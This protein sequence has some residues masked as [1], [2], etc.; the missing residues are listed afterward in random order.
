MRSSNKNRLKDKKFCINIFLVL[1][2]LLTIFFQSNINSISNNNKR[3][4]KSPELAASVS[5]L[6]NYT[7]RSYMRSSPALGDVDSDGIL[8]VIIGSGN[9]KVYALNGKDGSKLW[10]LYTGDVVDSS[11]ALGDVDGD[12][13]LE[14]VIGNWDNKVYALNGEDGSEFWNFT[15]GGD[16]DS[17]PAL[18]DV[19]GDGMLEVVVSS[20]DNKTYALNGEDGSELWNFSTGSGNGGVM[21]H[22]MFSSPALGDVDSD[23][24]LEVIIG[25]NDGNIYA[26]N[27]E[28][29][30][31]LW[32]F[33]TNV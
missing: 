2:I 25:S 17:S 18:G 13:T 27:G 33:T 22:P 21:N 24:M 12:G 28:D 20:K 3:L 31:K 5:T 11:P 32:N 9:H 30:S 10:S 6:W 16:V 23:G 19:D 1:N 15:T 26:L 14:V 7:T 8:E 4:L 29:G